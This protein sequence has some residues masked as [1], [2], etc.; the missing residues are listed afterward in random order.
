LGGRQDFVY[1]LDKDEEYNLKVVQA[2]VVA[3]GK[4][5]SSSS[6]VS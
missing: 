3:I 5:L 1:A 4:T 2:R 6:T